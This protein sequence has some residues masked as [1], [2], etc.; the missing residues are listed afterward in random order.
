MLCA[1]LFSL[2]DGL[3]DAGSKLLVVS[4]LLVFETK[5]KMAA[6]TAALYRAQARHGSL[7]QCLHGTFSLFSF[8]GPWGSD[9]LSRWA[10]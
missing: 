8:L 10:I 4:G 1:A 2:G 5:P 7:Q 9:F 3:L 6:D